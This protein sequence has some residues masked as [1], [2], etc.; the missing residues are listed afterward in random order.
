MVYD[1][2]KRFCDICAEASN[3]IDSIRLARLI[4]QL[5][6][7]SE[8][9]ATTYTLPSLCD[10]LA[11]EVVKQKERL[12]GLLV[13]PAIVESAIEPIAVEPEPKIFYKQEYV[14]CGKEKCRK[15]GVARVGHGPYWYAYT[16]TQGQSHKRYVGLNLP[17]DLP[18]D[19]VVV[20][21]ALP[22]K[23]AE[24]EALSCKQDCNQECTAN[25][26]STTEPC[27]R[28]ARTS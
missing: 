14:R 2:M 23:D 9:C 27:C 10:N 28:V 21:Y 1:Y 12:E 8:I 13:T 20:R 19:R 26:G 11:L 7:L 22:L 3:E 16:F 25:G 4:G 17:Q 18:P 5:E 6:I 15:C 24:G